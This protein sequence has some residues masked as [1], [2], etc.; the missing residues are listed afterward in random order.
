[1]QVRL[2]KRNRQIGNKGLNRIAVLKLFRLLEFRWE[3]TYI[4]AFYKSPNHVRQLAKV[5]I[6]L[7]IS[8]SSSAVVRRVSAH[9]GGGSVNCDDKVCGNVL[10]LHRFWDLAR[11]WSKIAYINLLRESPPV[12]GAAVGRGSPLAIV[13]RYCVTPRLAAMIESGLVTDRHMPR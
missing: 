7:A 4:S 5:D 12:F 13:W 1:M 6:Q 11:Y 2:L 10:I 3:V 9:G 8:L